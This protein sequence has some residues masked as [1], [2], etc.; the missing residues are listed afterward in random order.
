[1]NKNYD[2]NVLKDFRVGRYIPLHHFYPLLFAEATNKFVASKQRK[3][4]PKIPTAAMTTA[5]RAI[6]NPHKMR[7]KATTY[8][9][10][11]IKIYDRDLRRC[12]FHSEMVGEDQEEAEVKCL[13]HRKTVI[14]ITC[15]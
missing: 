9:T 1:M 15:D 8:T 4:A 6:A 3:A 12:Q 2:H 14:T 13:T 10:V 7:C 5:K 11:L